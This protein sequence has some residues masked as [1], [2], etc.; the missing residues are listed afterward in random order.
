MK[1]I[2][3]PLILTICFAVLL[4]VVIVP[5]LKNEEKFVVTNK[6]EIIYPSIVENKSELVNPF[7]GTDFHGHT[8]PGATMP[9]GM[10]QLSPDTRLDGWDGCSAYHYS[11]SIIYGFSH[12][13]L[14]GT[15]C[16]DYGDI[17]LLPISNYNN[18]IKTKKYFSK[19]DK[20]SEISSPGYYEVDLKD[21]NIKTQLTVTQRIGFHNYTYPGKENK[22]LIIDLEH[23]DK[24]IEAYIKQENDTLFTG[25]RH[26][27]AWAKNQYQ[28]FAIVFNQAVEVVDNV[29][30]VKKN[31]YSGNNCKIVIKSKNKTNDNLLVKVGLSAVNEKGA[32]ENL[33]TEIPF[34]N[35]EEI[36]TKAEET[37]NKELSRILVSGGTEEQ[38]KIF[39]SAL[40]H[41][42][43]VP[44]LYSDVDN[45][46]RGTDLKIHKDT[47]HDTYTV[48]SLWDTYRAAHPLYTITQQKRTSDFINTF[49]HQYQQGGQLPVW[50][51]SSN[52]TMCMI[53][54]HA[55]PP[56]VD[57]YFKGIKNFNTEL[58]L[59]AMISAANEKR[60]GKPEYNKFGYIPM[61][62]E[63][64]SVSKNL[65]YSFDN[66]CIAIFA[67][68]IG[69]EKIY[70]E[71]IAKAQYYKNTFN[72]KNCFMQQKINGAFSYPFDPREVNFNY[73]EA[74]S[75]QYSFYVPQDILTLIELH[76]GNEKFAEKLDQMFSET[77]ETTG[78][79]QVD[80]TGLIGQYA[81]GN[82][83]SHHVA[84][85]YNYCDQAWK[86]QKLT[87]QIMRDL[88]SEKPDGLCGNED[89][90][91]MSAWFVLSAMGIYPTNPANGIYDF[92]S[93]IFDSVKIQLENGKSFSIITHNNSLENVYINKIILNGNEYQKTYISH[94]E[95]MNG[96]IIEFFMDSI[97]NANF[98]K[99]KQSIYYS[100]IE[101]NEISSV[102]YSDVQSKSFLDSIVVSLACADENAEI[103]YSTK[104]DF[105]KYKKPIKITE[106]TKL[107]YYSKSPNKIQSKTVTAN[108]NRIPYKRGIKLIS[109]YSL[110]Y[111]AG[112]DNALI[113][114]VFGEENFKSG[115]WQG[116]KGQNFEAIIDLQ[117]ERNIISISSRFI[118][119]NRSWIFFPKKVIYYSSN[120]RKNF[121]KISELPS[122]MSD[123]DETVKIQE[124]KENYKK[125]KTR[126]IKVFAEYYGV[127]PKWHL[128]PGYDSWLFIDEI[129]ISEKE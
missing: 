66:W 22:Y 47:C 67:K 37:W 18:N 65:E 14:S 74:N 42:F 69:D 38:Q 106:D 70:K 7:I 127:L 36:K 60:L 39:Y 98:G 75:W 109:K 122:K 4:L 48:F 84:Y 101:D 1:R 86:T 6:T 94:Q 85:L 81:H 76:G 64:E 40:Y 5:K 32:L 63:H 10:V 100:K 103:F 3:I 43:I 118:Q 91:Q 108:Y 58:A 72:P 57:A 62:S 61:D 102:P 52:E 11:D 55:V 112:G 116:Y 88:Y 125:L 80:I 51:L 107:E 117:K 45:S 31:K 92:G 89:C 119:D 53:G 96:G 41:S 2:I 34:W 54:Y 12:T 13:H 29:G 28:Y 90:G 105:Q 46:Y 50:E 83:P 68:E 56:I 78:N 26:S 110:Q 77:T 129:E 124:F 59:K 120:D 35:F 111:S 20:N 93:P 114:Y 115:A 9:F 128:S 104:K 8:Y 113:D 73:T 79:G 121:Q 25:L 126:Y 27:E 82:E 44:N 49:L 87:R 17:L 24:V 19:F 21:F 123:R 97:P 33:K 30:K 99:D 71:Y 23:R 15:G 95:I 16:S